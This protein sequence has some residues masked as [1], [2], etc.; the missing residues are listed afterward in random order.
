MNINIDQL[1]PVAL[2]RY[3]VLTVYQ[4]GDYKITERKPT[5]RSCDGHFKTTRRTYRKPVKRTCAFAEICPFSTA[6]L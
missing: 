6:S 3:F 1:I 2:P 4:N 5:A